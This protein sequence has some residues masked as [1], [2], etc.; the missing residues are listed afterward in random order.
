M[1]FQGTAPPESLQL[2]FGHIFTRVLTYNPH[3]TGR[4]PRRGPGVLPFGTAEGQGG[5]LE[6][7]L[8]LLEGTLEGSGPPPHKTPLSCQHLCLVCL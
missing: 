5:L 3:L 8:R 1:I 7:P 4:I 6:D 2:L